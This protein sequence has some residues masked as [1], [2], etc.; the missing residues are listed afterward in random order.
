MSSDARPSSGCHWKTPRPQPMPW[1]RSA[2][3]WSNG[4]KTNS[5]ILTMAKSKC[6]HTWFQSPFVNS[7]SAR[8]CAS[9]RDQI[10]HRPSGVCNACFH[11]RSATNG[12]MYFHKIVIRIMQ[13]NRRFEILQFLA[14]CVREPRQASATTEA[15]SSHG[16]KRR[17]SH[18]NT[19]SNRENRWR[20]EKTTEKSSCKS[21]EQDENHKSRKRPTPVVGR[22]PYGKSQSNPWLISYDEF[23]E[24]S[25]VHP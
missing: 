11:C 14:E 17:E 23:H 15:A 1:R 9:H 13:R 25:V 19:T 4:G 8:S 20:T 7:Q 12:L 6:I 5:G 16:V 10:L 24:K 22:K 21:V 2:S 18:R 3:S